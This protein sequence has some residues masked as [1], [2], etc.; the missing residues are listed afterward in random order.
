MEEIIK[1]TEITIV[2]YFFHARNVSK[3][4]TELSIIIRLVIE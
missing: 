1:K 3:T 4:L 2:R